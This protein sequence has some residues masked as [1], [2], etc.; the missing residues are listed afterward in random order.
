MIEAD[1]EEDDAFGGDTATV[2]PIFPTKNAFPLMYGVAYESFFQS[3]MAYDGWQGT[4]PSSDHGLLGEYDLIYTAFKS[5]IGRRYQDIDFLA[6]KERSLALHRTVKGSLSLTREKGVIIGSLEFARGL[7]GTIVPSNGSF[8]FAEVGERSAN[9]IEYR[10]KD[11][12]TST[13]SEKGIDVGTRGVIEVIGRRVPLG[14]FRDDLTKFSKF[15]FA[16]GGYRIQGRV[17][18]SEAGSKLGWKCV[19]EWMDKYEEELDSSWLSRH[20]EFPADVAETIRR[21]LY[22]PPILNIEEGDLTLTTY[23]CLGPGEKPETQVSPIATMIIAR[24]C[25]RR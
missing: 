1:R 13:F 15:K 25:G 19:K 7:K 8:S 24:P 14:L 10:V 3:P 4:L 18:S 21:F 12:F 5:S 20:L 17:R 9:R 16:G 6:Q 22:P 11:Q 2:H 23:F